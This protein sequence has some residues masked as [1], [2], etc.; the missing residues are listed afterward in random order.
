MLGFLSGF[1]MTMFIEQ[2]EYNEEL[3]PSAGVRVLISPQDKQP[4]PEDDGFDVN[5]GHKTSV[6]LRLVR[7]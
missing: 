4:F 2:P 7:N 6:T 1:S 3:T 5:P